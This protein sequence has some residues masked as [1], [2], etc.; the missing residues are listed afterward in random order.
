MKEGNRKVHVKI[1]RA[2]IEEVVYVRE[3]R[4]ES[5][6]KNEDLSEVLR[7]STV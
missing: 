4:E 3:I 1:N 2:V 6:S 7:E 5:C